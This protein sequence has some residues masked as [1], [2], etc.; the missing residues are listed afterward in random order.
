MIVSGYPIRKS[1]F[2]SVKKEAV[3]QFKLE[4]GIFT[5]LVFGG[6]LGAVLINEISCRTL[7]RMSLENNL[8]V[9]HITGQK[10][11]EFIKEKVKNNARYKIFEYAHNMSDFYA[12]SDIAVCRS[13]A[14]AVFELKA[15]NKSAIFVPYPNAADNHQYL[16]AKEIEKSGKFVIIEEKNLNEECL[17]K[18]LLFL[19]NAVRDERV[20]KTRRS[21]QEEIFKE[22]EK[23]IKY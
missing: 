6:S 5:V 9:L 1:I 22:I 13:G 18:A 16:N 21:P 10:K 3:K 11:F 23:C 2:S 14:G 12:A 17:K 20:F 4:E 15:L 7:L 19:K 8:Q